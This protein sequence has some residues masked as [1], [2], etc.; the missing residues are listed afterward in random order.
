MY[1]RVAKDKK[2]LLVPFLLEGVANQ[3][4]LFQADRIHPTAG[5]QPIMLSNVWPHV[6]PLLLK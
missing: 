6:K 4:Q 5:A 3:E 2:T 1:S